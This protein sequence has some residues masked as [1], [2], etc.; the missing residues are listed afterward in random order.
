MATAK[1][2]VARAVTRVHVALYRLTGG[3]LGSRVAGMPVLLLTTRGSRTGKERTT[4]LG[5]LEDGDRLVLVA[6][7]GGD[8]RH[9]GWYHN[10]RAEPEVKVTRGRLTQTRV[11]RTAGPEEKAELWPRIVAAYP[12]YDK[13]QEKTTRDIPVVILTP[14]SS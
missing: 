2:R 7:Y 14:A 9:P 11:A 3:R 10:L 12:G 13:Y 6:S 1:D 4:P 8:P 5:F